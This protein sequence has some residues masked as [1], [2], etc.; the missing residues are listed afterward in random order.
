M[1]GFGQ[2]DKW[3]IDRIENILGTEITTRLKQS[4]I[5]VVNELYDDGYPSEDIYD[6]VRGILVEQLEEE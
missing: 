2:L 1:E 4:I 6:Y 3:T 5:Q